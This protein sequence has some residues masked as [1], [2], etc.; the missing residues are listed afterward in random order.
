MVTFRKLWVHEGHNCH[1]QNLI[2]AKRGYNPSATGPETFQYSTRIS[3]NNPTMKHDT[4][5]SFYT[6]M[7]G[8]CHSSNL[9]YCLECN[10]CHMKYMGQSKNRILDR[11]W[12]NF[13]DIRNHWSAIVAMHFASH[14]QLYNPPF[15]ICFFEYT[16]VLKDIPRSKS[17]RQKGVGLDTQVKHSNPQLP[18]Q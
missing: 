1:G 13:F 15:Q 3:H 7:H 11:F 6:I 18:K 9:I 12:G 14:G 17:M 2:L 4:T 16:K 8:N 5:H 10:I